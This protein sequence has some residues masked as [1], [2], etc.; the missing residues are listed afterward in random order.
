VIKPVLPAF[1]TAYP[2][3]SIKV[4]I[5]YGFR[6]IITDRFDAGIRLGKKIEQDMI[7][8]KVGGDLRMAVVATPSYLAEH[9]TPNDP[10]ELTRHRC[11]NYRLV[12]AG[13]TYTWEFERGGE[14]LEVRVD[15]P[16]TFNEPDLMLEAALE[17]LGVAYVLE[18][19]A[20]QFVAQGRLIRL[21]EEW[22][23]AFPGFFLYHPSR[24]QAR[25]VLTAFITLARACAHQT[26]KPTL[27]I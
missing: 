15:G 24:R 27:A 23:P 3:A 5:D 1:T 26:G 7:A 20:A 10:R 6:D 22:T 2:N 18:G 14:V 12:A 8:I 13:S 11:I 25:P 17:G 21:L 19:R 4:L 16:L 9:G